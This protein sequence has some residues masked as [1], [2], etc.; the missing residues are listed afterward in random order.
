MLDVGAGATGA[1]LVLQT[2]ATVALML[3]KGNRLLHQALCIVIIAALV[4]AVS[5]ILSAPG[6]LQ[7]LC[8]FVTPS[9]L[10]LSSVVVQPGG[11]IFPPFSIF[12]SLVLAIT[13]PTLI[14]PQAGSSSY[15][16][17]SKSS[18]LHPTTGLLQ[19]AS[20]L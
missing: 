17:C 19:R 11:C 16:C 6:R 8:P 2:A 13:S 3:R 4:A 15:Q 18:V 5:T 10:S 1:A 9:D 12:F 7:T 20:R 14:R